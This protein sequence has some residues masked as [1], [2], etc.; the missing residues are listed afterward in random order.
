MYCSVQHYKTTIYQF[1]DPAAQIRET[2]PTVPV[3][4]ATGWASELVWMLQSP[5]YLSLPGIEM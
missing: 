5:F 3:G 1:D 2:G 4:Q